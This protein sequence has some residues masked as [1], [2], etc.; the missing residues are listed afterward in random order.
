MDVSQVS[1]LNLSW[2]N[3]SLLTQQALVKRIKNRCSGG[4]I[5]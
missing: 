1:K 2:C 5:E 3:L 4:V